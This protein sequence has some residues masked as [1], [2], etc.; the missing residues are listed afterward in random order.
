MRKRIDSGFGDFRARIEE[1][2]V[3]NM[4]SSLMTASSAAEA[5]PVGFSGELRP[6]TASIVAHAGAS[7][8]PTRFPRSAPE[9]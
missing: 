3:Y 2:T 9:R 1:G 8:G 5:D 4:K 7:S 6:L